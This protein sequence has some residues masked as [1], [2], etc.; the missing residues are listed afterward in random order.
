M[1]FKWTHI[2]KIELLADNDGGTTAEPNSCREIFE[3][4]AK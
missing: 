4:D 2:N 1:I 3:G